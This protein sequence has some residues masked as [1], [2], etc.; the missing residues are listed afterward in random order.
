MRPL[1]HR[2]ARGFPSVLAIPTG[3]RWAARV[4]AYAA[5]PWAT[6]RLGRA[7]SLNTHVAQ[8][9]HD[10]KHAADLKL[11]INEIRRLASPEGAARRGSGF[12]RGKVFDS[13]RNSDGRVSDGSW[14]PGSSIPLEQR[15]ERL[16]TAGILRGNPFGRRAIA[17]RGHIGRRYVLPMTC[18]AAMLGG[19]V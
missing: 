6:D 2:A 4:R 17:G 18:A 19:F 7:V 15:M 5:A 14:C 12:L 13:V 11:T 8:P 1:I 16:M 10:E 3:S 9:D